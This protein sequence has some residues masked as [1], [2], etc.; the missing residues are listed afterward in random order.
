VPRMQQALPVPHHPPHPRRAGLHRAT[1][2]APRSP[3]VKLTWRGNAVWLLDEL[4]E[5]PRAAMI[6]AVPTCR[7]HSLPEPYAATSALPR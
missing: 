1:A 6:M 2:P 5:R 7:S 3:A 4:Q